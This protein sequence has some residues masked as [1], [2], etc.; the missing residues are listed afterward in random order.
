MSVARS[1]IQITTSIKTHIHDCSET[2]GHLP[3]V[4]W[5]EDGFSQHNR[6]NMLHDRSSPQRV[7]KRSA[8]V[9][10]MGAQRPADGL[11]RKFATAIHG[12]V[13]ALTCNFHKLLKEVVKRGSCQFW[14]KWS[15][16]VKM[17][18]YSVRQSEN[19]QQLK[20][21][22]YRHAPQSHDW[23]VLQRRRASLVAAAIED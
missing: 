8:K 18:N 2:V 11:F 22:N 13:I 12:A 6:D 10:C 15:V 5:T 21:S 20:V 7:L 9:S 4:L 23:R 14:G 17:R 3:L 16:T 1:R 19:L